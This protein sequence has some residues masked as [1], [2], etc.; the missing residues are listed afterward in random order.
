M[1][2]KPT[3]KDLMKERYWHNLLI[4]ARNLAVGFP[5]A[6]AFSAVSLALL[7]GLLEGI[8]GMN[9]INFGA[10][11]IF[12]VVFT[13]PL[14]WERQKEAEVKR[15]YLAMLMEENRHYDRKKEAESTWHSSF[16]WIE[17]WSLYTICIL[18]F[19]ISLPWCIRSAIL[20]DPVGNT[21]LTFLSMW[22]PIAL[23]LVFL[24]IFGT[25]CN[26]VL[27]L[28]ARKKWDDEKLHKIN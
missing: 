3:K 7:G 19:V 26:F 27:W 5:I 11:I 14:W 10:L 12:C 15:N 1:D 20:L 9:I 24:V 2:E 16:F 13:L 21:G 6:Y 25:A 28:A 4:Y 18:V 23:S 17:N 8:V 22:L